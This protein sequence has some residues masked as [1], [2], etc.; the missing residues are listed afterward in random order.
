MEKYKIIILTIIVVSSFAYGQNKTIVP[1]SGTIVFVKKD[2]IKDQKLHIQSFRDLQPKFIKALKEEIY[3]ER[4]TDGK[5]TDTTQL[6]KMAVELAKAYEF[7]LT[8]KDDRILK[9]HCI[10]E[11][12]KISKFLEVNGS[13]YDLIYINSKTNTIIDKNNQSVD[14]ENLQSEIIDLKEFKNEIKIINGYSCYKIVY[15]YKITS[16]SDFEQL[17]KI[18][19]NKREL[20][21]TDK[22]KSLYHPVINDFQILER[23]YPLK[24]IEYS[25]EL[26]GFQTYYTLEKFDLK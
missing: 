11:N 8:E 12:E 5:K 24:I 13:E 1:V 3:L 23:Y 18:T 14:Y 25:D 26:K 2:S 16:E 9:Y 20:W 19:T 7:V 22:I 17:S 4:L 15:Q 21:V 10:Y 6:N